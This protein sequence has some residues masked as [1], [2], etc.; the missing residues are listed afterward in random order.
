MTEE[1]K[2]TLELSPLAKEVATLRAQLAQ[3]QREA[4][5]LKLADRQNHLRCVHVYECQARVDEAVAATWEEA[6]KV[7]DS[8]IAPDTVFKGLCDQHVELKLK[9]IAAALRARGAKQCASCG[10]TWS[11]SM[12]GE[13]QGPGSV[14]RKCAR[15]A[16]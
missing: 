3:V 15:G 7:L 12:C 14:C 5:A 1:L 9:R 11:H 16:K 10:V 8:E 4:G 13:W 2:A 6:A